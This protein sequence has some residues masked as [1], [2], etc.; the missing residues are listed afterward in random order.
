MGTDATLLGFDEARAR[1]L[2]DVRRLSRERIPLGTAAGRVLAEDLVASR[3]L[4]PFDN[5]SMDGYAVA[6]TDLDGAGPWQLAVRGES[7]AGA[8][9]PTLEAA[10]ACRIFTGAPVPAR[11]DAVVMQEHAPRDGDAIRLAVRPRAGQHIRR[12]GEDI[13][14]GVLAIP[15]GTRASA[16]TLALAAML[17]RFELVVARRPHVTILCTGDELRARGD[18]ARAATIP[19]SNSAPLS[20]L[21]RQA[22]SVVRIAPIARDDP[23][24]ATRAIEQ[25]LEGTD[26]L[27]TVGGV[28]VGDHDVVRPALERA[29]VRLDFW[30]IAIK[31]GKPLA[32]GRKGATHI[33]GLPRNPASAM[34][35]FA[36][37]GI[38]LLRAL[39][40]DTRPIAQ[41]LRVRLAASRSRSS[42][43][44]ELVRASLR[45]DGDVLA[46]C[47][48]ENQASGAATSLASS[49]GVAF[50]PA[51]GTA[52]DAG[53]FVDF[54]RWSDA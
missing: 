30:R 33:L 26:V 14:K 52:I 36:L 21:A 35:T 47:V 4:P 18:D 32:V 37:F 45:H 41:P 46:A 40:G 43:R 16:G 6:T 7:T 19:E 17:D 22:A 39:Q 27:L 10:S 2:A 34:V 42:D 49:D 13:A 29:G 20:A 31:P 48:H 38:P 1:I 12:A 54:V 3:P 23:S 24:E 50:V 5:S 11:A 51:G 15:D 8:A 28:S 25:A 44:L 53:V 9:A